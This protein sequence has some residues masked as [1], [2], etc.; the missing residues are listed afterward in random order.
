MDYYEILGVSQGASN[1]DIKKAYRKLV[2]RYHPDRN[3]NDKEAEAKIREINAAYEVIG[4]SE[5]RQSYERLRYGDDVRDETPDPGAVLS[6][7]EQKLYD[8]GRKEV[9]AVLMKDVKRVKSELSAIRE[10]TVSRQGYDTFRGPIVL[11]R[12]GEVILEFV[13]PET[14]ARKQRLL[15]VAVQMMATAR[16]IQ[17]DDERQTRELKARFEQ[18]F[19]R[20]RLGGFHDALEL[21]YQ[22]K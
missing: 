9:F 10:R 1:E 11:E 3:P 5:I 7:M 13:T 15:E 16:V 17:R 8:E 6:A 4:D 21:F 20:G 14:E 2:L 12:A 22:R 18:S 19:D